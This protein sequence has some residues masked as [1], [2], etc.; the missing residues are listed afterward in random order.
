MSKLYVYEHDV[1]K[2]H[3]HDPNEYLKTPNET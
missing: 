2:Y 3:E 1:S